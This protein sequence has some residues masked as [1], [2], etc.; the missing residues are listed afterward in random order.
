MDNVQGHE[1]EVRSV[2]W[3]MRGLLLATCGGDK[4][5]WIW[6]ALPGDEFDCASVL[7][8]HTADVKIVQW[9]AVNE[10]L[11]VSSDNNIKVYLR[12]YTAH[13]LCVC[14][15]YFLIKSLACFSSVILSNL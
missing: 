14:M 13:S 9:N 3:D 12:G 11:S 10:L 6:E 15:Y 1:N 2:S 7:Q 5:I 4:S 8:G